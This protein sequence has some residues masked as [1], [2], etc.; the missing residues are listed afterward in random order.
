MMINDRKIIISVGN[1]RRSMNWK[2]QALTL[3]ELYEKLRIPAR[4]A[5]TMNAYLALKKAEQDELKDVSGFVGGSLN[6][7][8][9][10]ASAVTGR[11]VITLDLDNIPAGGTDDVRRRIEGLGCGYCVYSTRKH[12]PAAPRL[13]VL[14]PIDRT[15]TADE[16][17]PL[18]R[19]LAE[20]I[21]MELADPTTFDVSR[22]M[23]FPSCCADGEYIHA[24]QDKPLA[25]VDG[26]LAT[27]ADWRD[28]ASW[29]RHGGEIAHARLAIRQGDPTTKMGVVGAFCRAYDVCAA[30]DEFLPGI[31]D[32]VD[33]MPGRYT[34]LGGSTTGGAVTY[35][36]GKFLFSHH[37]TDPCGGKLVNAFDLVRLHMFGD[38]DDDAEPNTPNNRLPS[39][40]AMLGLAVSDKRVS[41]LMAAE[42]FGEA[43][44]TET[45]G[46]PKNWATLLDRNTNGDYKK[47]LKNI[48]LLLQNHPELA[49]CAKRDLFSTRI[50]A[51]DGLPWPRKDGSAVW[52]DSDTTELR[53]FMERWFKPAK[54]DVGDAL[55]AVA[56]LQAFHPVRDYLSALKWDGAPR[57]DTLFIKYLGV[58]DTEYTRAV[59]RKSIVACVARVMTP[60]CKADYMPVFVGGQGRMK[61]SILHQLGGAW[62]SDS[63][64]T[65][66]GKEGMESLLGKWIVEIP[67]MHAFDRAEMNA[68][69][70]FITKQSDFFRAAYAE[71]A[72]ENPR[73]CVFFGTTNNAECL[74]DATGGRRFWI[75][76]IDKR[77]RTKN[78][79]IDLPLERD[80][81]WAEAVVRFGAGEKLFL[82]EHLEE[83]ARTHQEEHREAHPWEDTII[84]FLAKEVPEDWDNWEL[85]A[86]LTYWGGGAAGEQKT[87]PRTKVCRKEIWL[88]ALGGRGISALTPAQSRAITTILEMSPNWEKAPNAFR[89]GKPYGVQKG[90][91]S[92]EKCNQLKKAE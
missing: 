17:E 59:T 49:G 15:A 69:K 81:I 25:S 30:M 53:L 22:L 34:F 21:G 7:T 19:K 79:F 63:L 75:L 27:Y 64:T 83:R 67:E 3:S 82:P 51:V 44:D 18:A 58:E 32:A 26:L 20:I 50:C 31:Y 85:S 87:V 6:G 29:P 91:R 57:L 16:Y 90:Y 1:H 2:P 23:Y 52:T 4:G 28:I 54:Q 38:K 78:V 41:E 77:E 76:T 84:D 65:F 45:A 10:K 40:S 13:R 11:D 92:K 14:I 55:K 46:E 12:S 70:G 5:E 33:T 43:A 39:Y 89:A 56:D 37:A 9:R 36:N 61:S 88:E 48:M 35:D 72:R 80:Q 86:R 42:D 71:Y 24:W 47:T 66:M 73:Q 62:F 60:G 8:R 74:R 68:I